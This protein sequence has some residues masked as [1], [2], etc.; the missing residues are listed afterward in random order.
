MLKRAL[1]VQ[2]Y[3]TE[4]FTAAILTLKSNGV[5][6]V[7]EADLLALLNMTFDGINENGVVM[8]SNVVPALDL[9]FSQ[10]ITANPSFILLQ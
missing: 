1:R 2:L 4:I 6:K 3:A 5:D 10:P 8:N 9:L 7:S